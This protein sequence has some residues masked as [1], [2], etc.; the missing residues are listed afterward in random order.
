MPLDAS[1][2]DP[3]Q[4]VRAFDIHVAPAEMTAEAGRDP[5]L[6]FADDSIRASAVPVRHGHAMRRHGVT[7]SELDHLRGLHTD[8]TEV[9]AVAEQAGVRELILT[10]YLP[11]D[12]REITDAEWAERASHGF[13][14]TTTAGYDGLR[15]R[16]P[17]SARDCIPASPEPPSES[18]RADS[19]IGR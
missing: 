9:G 6:V 8:V 11:A 13:S 3:G 4:L 10:H 7:G 14:G 12:P 18:D 19:R 15:R 1:M 17:P 5:V 16:L 2:P